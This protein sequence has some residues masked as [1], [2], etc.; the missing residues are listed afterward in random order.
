MSGTTLCPHCGTR[1]KIAKT[2]LEAHHGM[3]RCGHCLQAFDT[4]PNF[5]PEEIDPQLELPLLEDTLAEAEQ[6]HAEEPGATSQDSVRAAVL[7]PLM[8]AD[9]A[10][11][12]TGARDVE[13]LSKRRS[14]LWTI[15]A[16]PL[17]LLL[18]AQTAYLF[19]IEL[20]AH[21]PDLK[22]TLVH[23]CQIMKCSVPLPQKAGMM[24]IESSELKDDPAHG[25]RIMLIAQLRNRASYAQA[26]PDLELTLTDSQDKALARRVFRP[27]DYLPAPQNITAG[28]SANQELGI[29][30]HL[31][32]ADLKPLGYRLVLYYSTGPDS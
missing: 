6:P 20:A 31:D 27:E 24:S 10:V 32:T 11:F 15:A 16:L 2:Q 25:N 1:F 8:L 26:F 29:M 23:F 3:V 14:R 30:L 9:K 7:Q 22:P 13:F 28:L 17:L 5:A 4:R 19:R 12:L 18:L 21:L